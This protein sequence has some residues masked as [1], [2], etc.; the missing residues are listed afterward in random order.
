MDKNKTTLVLLGVL[1]AA[2]LLSGCVEEISNNVT[3]T[4]SPTPT[5]KGTPSTQSVPSTGMEV[6]LSISNAPALNETAEL[7]CTITSISDAYNTTAQIELPAGLVLVSGNLSW[8]GDI[9]VPE[10]EKRKHPRPSL[11]SPAWEKYEYPKGKA[12]FSVLVKSAEVGNWTIA[13][14]A[15]YNVFTQEGIQYG[16]LGDSDYIY[17]AVREDTAWISETL[18]TTEGPAPARQLNVTP[19]LPPVEPPTENITIHV[20]L[21]KEEDLDKIASLIKK[22]RIY[23]Q[24]QIFLGNVIYVSNKLN[25]NT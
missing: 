15:G 8:N 18:F 1:I 5:S 13:A 4:P 6:N 7:T 25:I 2:V 24:T 3:V 21:K 9:I 11:G 14:T 20:Q 23:K 10:E 12:E 17:V 19:S 22:F 16:R